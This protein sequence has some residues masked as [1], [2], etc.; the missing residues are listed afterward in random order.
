[1]FANQISMREKV[2]IRVCFCVFEEH[3]GCDMY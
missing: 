2:K 3:R 1:M